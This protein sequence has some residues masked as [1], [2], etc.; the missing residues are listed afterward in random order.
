MPLQLGRTLPVGGSHVIDAQRHGT[1]I[2]SHD[3]SQG[4]DALDAAGKTQAT[5]QTPEP[6]QA[7]GRFTAA[8]IKTV[9]HAVFVENLRGV[10]Q[11]GVDACNRRVLRYGRI[12]VVGAIQGV[13]KIMAQVQLGRWIDRIVAAQAKLAPA[14]AVNSVFSDSKNI[15]LRQIGYGHRQ[16]DACA[17]KAGLCRG[18]GNRRRTWEYRQ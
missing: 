18:G 14:A 11:L 3:A 7:N 12:E 6:A 13:G 2:V 9:A 5:L 15:S 4:L 16:L 17:G 1:R 8:S 10:R